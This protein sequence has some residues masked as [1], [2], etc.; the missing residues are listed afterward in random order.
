MRILAATLISALIVIV[1]SSSAAHADMAGHCFQE[2]DWELRV[3]GCTD[4]IQSA[5]WSGS[6]LAWAYTNRCY[7]FIELGQAV[8][9]IAD[10]D[11]AIHLDPDSPVAYNNRGVAYRER[12]EYEQALDD[13]SQAI[14]L[15]PGFASPYNNR[16]N[17]YRD[18]G[19]YE[20]AI[21]AFD[22]AIQ[23]SPNYA[24]AYN[25]LGW[26]YFNLG[27]F[28]L[29]MQNYNYAIRL[30]PGNDIVRSNLAIAQNGLAWKLYS[31]G[32]AAEGL[33]YVDQS[34]DWSPNTV[35]FINTR[36]H[37]YAAVG[38]AQDALA[39]FERAMQV[40]GADAVQF[41]EEALARR[42]YNPGTIDGHYRDQTR[43]ALQAC[44]EAGC[45]LVE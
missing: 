32:H 26:T 9:A 20:R 15:D 16:G 30:D 5:Q 10:C 27:E 42:G 45:R 36:A 7:A 24:T 12:G 35:P 3:E 22:Q 6:E 25:N 41:Y 14:L 39:E 19:Q 37:I 40:G 17:V 11:E 23:L 31:T 29:A 13:Y 8:R 2:S 1:R 33:P 34:L 21:A 44:L 18:L 43:S 28:R 4:V 38:R